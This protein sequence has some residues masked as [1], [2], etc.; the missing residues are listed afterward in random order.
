MAS[1]PDKKLHFLKTMLN[2]YT[3]V[4]ATKIESFVVFHEFVTLGLNTLLVL[5]NYI[6]ITIQHFIHNRYGYDQNGQ[7]NITMAALDGA[8]GANLDTI[9]EVANKNTIIRNF[10]RLI[11]L[12]GGYAEDLV[13]LDFQ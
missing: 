13:D 2:D 7:P 9:T 6:N 10:E 12:S 1:S 3:N 4:V 5:N 8:G 11:A